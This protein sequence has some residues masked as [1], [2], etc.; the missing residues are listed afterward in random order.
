[1]HNI[2]IV[3]SIC[4]CLDIIISILYLLLEIILIFI[5]YMNKQDI[6]IDENE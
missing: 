2:Y 1:M 3:G 4:I 6:T 5:Y